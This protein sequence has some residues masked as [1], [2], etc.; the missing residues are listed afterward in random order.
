[1]PTGHERPECLGVVGFFF[2]HRYPAQWSFR[3]Y[4]FEQVLYCTRCGLAA[5]GVPAKEETKHD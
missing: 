1:M 4:R 2:G 3:D 5:E